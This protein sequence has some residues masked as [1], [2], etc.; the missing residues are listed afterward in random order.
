MGS[1]PATQELQEHR[2]GLLRAGRPAV[3]ATSRS[4]SGCAT[5]STRNLRSNDLI[6]D[7]LAES[8]VRRPR[9]PGHGRPRQRP[10]QHPAALRFRVGHA[11][12]RPHGA[13]RRAT[14][15]T[16][17]ATA[18]GS[19]SAA[20]SSATSSRPRS[21]IRRCCGSIPTRP[22]SLGGRTLEDYIRTAGGRALY[23]PGDDLNLPYV[24]QRDDRHRQD[25][26][27]RTRRSKSTSSTRRRRTCRPGA[28][29]TCRRAG[30]WRRNPRPYPQFSSVTL[31]NSLTDSN[32]D[33]L[34]AQ[35]RR[36]YRAD[37]LAGVVHLCEGHLEGHQR[38]RQHQHRSLAH[39]RQRR[40]RARRERS[41][42]GAVGLGDRAAAVG[43]PARRDRVA[44]RRQP[45]GHHRRR[46]PRPRRQQPGSAGRTREEC[47]RP[48]ERGRTSR[49]S[50]RS[51]SRGTWRRSRWSS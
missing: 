49:S 20:T 36:R 32:Y 22:R 30:R 12:R 7:L 2:V 11:R 9:E 39:V 44:A 27:R 46:R 42:S 16:R 13:A 23:L 50:T 41:P 48:G 25:A 18:R 3:S 29:P 1:G 8:A 47:R 34:Q 28:T 17:A 19:T 33:A 38:Q 5:T 37:H 4:T 40:P 51:G 43:H 14:G 35:L 24:V 45:V 31:I 10:Q 15:S 21:P 6:A 26:A